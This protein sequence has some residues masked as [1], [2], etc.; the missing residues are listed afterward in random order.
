MEKL[1]AASGLMAGLALFFYGMR[2]MS[3]ALE[4]AG[5]ERLRRGLAR[6]TGRPLAGALAGAAATAVLQSSSAVTV[7]AVGFVNAGLMDLGQAIAV[8]F[9]ANV[10]T[11]VTGQLLAFRPEALTGPLL[12]AGLA[13]AQLADRARTRDAGEAIFGL[14]LLFQGMELM[15]A[16]MEP[17]AASPFWRWLM[18]RA[19]GAPLLGAGVGAL[20]TA[21][22]QS[23]SAAV[24]VLQRLAAQPG[25][26]GLDLAGAVPILLGSNI[27]TTVTALI[28]ATGGSADAKRAALA[29]A[30]FNLTGALIFL[31][32]LPAFTHLVKLLSPAGPREAVIARQLANAHT[33]FNLGCAL[34]WL[35]FTRG[36]ERLVTA[37]VPDK[38]PPPPEKGRRRVRP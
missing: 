14:A 30:L 21:A 8:V 17:L 31:P 38:R 5:G 27:G 24:A 19:S 33:L 28:A 25:P 15:G 34:A 9:G 37:M 18:G 7:M 29:H 26:G 22:M 10:G 1:A 23:S 6:A 4:R 3:Q 12:L 36:M 11:T 35:P 2:A 13:A 20:M 16:A 32:L